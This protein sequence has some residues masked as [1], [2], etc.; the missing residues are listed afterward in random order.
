MM[1]AKK[2][3][4]VAVSADPESMAKEGIRKFNEAVTAAVR[5]QDAAAKASFWTENTRF[6]PPGREMIRGRTA[7]QDFWQSGFD[8]G[9][10]DLVLESV[11]IKSLG[12]RV[13]YEIGRSI[14][15]VRT[16]DGSSIDIPGKS[17]CIFRREADGVW[18]ADVD[19]FNATP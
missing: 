7:V 12:D 14:T 16:A 19:I 17:L 18:R 9:T 11:E 1:V 8:H 2:R 15:R 3:T 6:L 13:A 4:D 5:N 10:Y